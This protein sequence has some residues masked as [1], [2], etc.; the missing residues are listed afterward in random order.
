MEERIKQLETEVSQ[1]EIKCVQSGQVVASLNKQN[2]TLSS[3]NHQLETEILDLKQKNEVGESQIQ[4]IGKTTTIY[5]IDIP[6]VHHIECGPFLQYLSPLFGLPNNDDHI[7][8]EAE[9][10]NNFLVNGSIRDSSRVSDLQKITSLM[11]EMEQDSFSSTLNKLQENISIVE[12]SI[13]P[14]KLIWELT[15]RLA[16]DRQHPSLT[17]AKQKLCEKRDETLDRLQGQYADFINLLD[18]QL[19]NDKQKTE[20]QQKWKTQFSFTEESKKICKALHT[21]TSA[22]DQQTLF[23]FPDIDAVFADAT[24]KLNQVHSDY[25][26]L[27]QTNTILLQRLLNCV[28]QESETQVR[29]SK[30]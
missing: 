28:K 12:K 8:Y 30:E 24:N 3:A 19:E 26:P 29:L 18:R 25:L 16:A 23:S 1:K 17:S 6:R 27:V 9:Q 22:Q 5:M 2:H 20:Q 7:L 21:N 15:D 13:L 4:E 10:A 14:T 11:E